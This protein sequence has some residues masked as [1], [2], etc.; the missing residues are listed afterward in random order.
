M[1][2]RSAIKVV[3]AGAFHVVAVRVGASSRAFDARHVRKLALHAEEQGGVVLLLTD[4]YATH[5]AWP[6]VLRV[7]LLRAL[8]SISVK[9]TRDRRGRTGAAASVSLAA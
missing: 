5:A 2:F 7:E 8:S 3:Q 6:V 1:L 4:A 9:I